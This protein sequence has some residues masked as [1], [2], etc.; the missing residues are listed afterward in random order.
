MSTTTHK[1]TYSTAEAAVASGLSERTILRAIKAGDLKATRPRIAGQP[2]G[3][4]V[5]DARELRR[6]LNDEAAVR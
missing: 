4:D 3:R 5:I 1:M 2:V 6:W